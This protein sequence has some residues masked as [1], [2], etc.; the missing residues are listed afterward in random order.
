[1]KVLYVRNLLLSTTEVQILETFSAFGVVERVK[2]IKDYAFVHFQ[3]REDAHKAMN[4]INGELVKFPI[5]EIAHTMGSASKN[6]LNCTHYGITCPTIAGSVLDG[7]QVEVTLAKPVDKDTYMRS[8]K[9]TR[10]CTLPAFYIP[11]DQFGTVLPCYP[12]YFS[13]P[14]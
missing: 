5:L 9:M 11:V 6:A 3:S 4:A 10:S 2:K 12:S 1:M 14:R 7:A 8:P 13:P